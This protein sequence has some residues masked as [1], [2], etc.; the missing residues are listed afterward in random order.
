MFSS[1][2]INASLRNL[3]RSSERVVGPSWKLSGLF[4]IELVN[5]NFHA[6][7]QAST[8]FLSNVSENV[9]SLQM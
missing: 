2:I 7:T 8:H 5:L 4:G 1:F 3:R 9:V 6:T